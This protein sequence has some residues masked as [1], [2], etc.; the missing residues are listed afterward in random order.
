MKVRELTQSPEE[1]K[2]AADVAVLQWI[3]LVDKKWG[4]S[5]SSERAFLVEFRDR[6]TEVL[7]TRKEFQI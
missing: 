2:V 4:A 5:P 3:P 1:A 6:L 7:N